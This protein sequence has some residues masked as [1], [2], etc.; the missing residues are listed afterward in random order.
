MRSRTLS[1]LLL[2]ALAAATTLASLGCSQTPPPPTVDNSAVEETKSAEATVGSEAMIS[3]KD[4]KAK[5]EG[6][7]LTVKSEGTDRSGLFIPAEYEPLVADG[8]FI[9]VYRFKSA[10]EARG[11]ARTVDAGGYVLAPTPD[12]LVN[13]NWTGWPAFFRSGDLVVI[14]VTEKGAANAARDKRVYAALIDALGY[15]FIGGNTPPPAAHG[16]AATS[17]PSATGSATGTGTGD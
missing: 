17:T 8:A 4:L 10:G 15:P 12:Q 1:L 13:V 9:Q 6:S 16:S 2:G 5:L 3:V 11:A 7:G 14:F